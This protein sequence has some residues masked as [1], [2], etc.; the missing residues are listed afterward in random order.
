M[1]IRMIATI[2]A[3]IIA[4]RSSDLRMALSL[5][6]ITRP[7]RAA[8][9]RRNRGTASPTAGGRRRAADTREHSNQAGR[10]RVVRARLGADELGAEILRPRSR[11][12]ARAERGTDG[13]GGV[14]QD[15]R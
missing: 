8:G 5:M 15:R 10:G 1:A 4:Q 12:P 14:P 6:A 3:T 2:P 9:R 7:S 13:G 11:Y